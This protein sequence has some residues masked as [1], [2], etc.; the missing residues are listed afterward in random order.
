MFIQRVDGI[1]E[2]QSQGGWWGTVQGVNILPPSSSAAVLATFPEIISRIAAVPFDA[3]GTFWPSPSNGEPVLGPLIGDLA[4]TEG[5]YATFADFTA[6]RIRFRL[7][8][9]EDGTIHVRR[10]NPAL[11]YL[12]LLELL[13][14]VKED[15]EMNSPEPM[16]LW[17]TDYWQFMFDAERTRVISV[18][19]WE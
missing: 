13:H 6:A 15:P 5:P 4:G 1:V 2:P 11:Y 12:S 19:D 14:L 9:L 7:A 17:H 18:I 3:I 8:A 16:Y 10:H